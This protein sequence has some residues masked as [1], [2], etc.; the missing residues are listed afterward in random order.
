MASATTAFRSRTD[1][2]P[3]IQDATCNRRRRRRQQ[4]GIDR[5]AVSACRLTKTYFA[6]EQT[7]RMRFLLVHFTGCFKKTFS[8]FIIMVAHQ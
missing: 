3:D 5:S 1:P 7:V 8:Q 6:I 4:N 2:C